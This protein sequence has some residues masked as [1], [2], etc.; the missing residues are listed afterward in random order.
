MRLLGF[1]VGE[2]GWPVLAHVALYGVACVAL[3][4]LATYAV[5]APVLKLRDRLLPARPRDPHPAAEAGAP[6]GDRACATT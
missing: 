4:W 6:T 2:S 5:E 3:G 1:P